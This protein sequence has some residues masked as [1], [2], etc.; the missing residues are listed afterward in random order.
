MISILKQFKRQTPRFG[1]AN[2]VRKLRGKKASLFDF[3]VTPELT[4][5]VHLAHAGRWIGSIGERS[6]SRPNYQ[7]RH[8]TQIREAQFQSV[9]ALRSDESRDDECRSDSSDR[10]YRSSGLAAA[11]H[12]EAQ[13]AGQ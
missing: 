9:R 4:H 8:L 5:R 12:V 3:R 7:R 11:A 13:N 10:G 1:K 6:S 2:P